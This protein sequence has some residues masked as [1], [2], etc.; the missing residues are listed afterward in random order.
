MNDHE[1][2]QSV[3]RESRGALLGLAAILAWATSAAGV[4]WIGRRLGTWQYL[5]IGCLIGC[6]GQV[7]CYRLLGRSPQD[8]FRLPWRQW[9]LAVLGF[10]LYLTCYAAGLVAAVTD[11]Q[12]VGVSL[13]NYLWPVLT[14]VLAVVLVPGTRLTPRV[15][16]ALAVALGGL[17]V[18]NWREIGRVTGP[19]AVLPYVLGGLAGI[20]WALYSAL[21]ARWRDRGQRYATAPAG[22]LMISLIGAIVCVFQG[23]WRPVTTPTWLALLYVGLVPN[24]AGYL[25]WEWALHRASPVTLGLLG[26]GTPML[27]TLCLLGLFTLT[28]QSRITPHHWGP[29]LL[30]AGL[31]AAAVLLVSVKPGAERTQNLC[32]EKEVTT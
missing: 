15:G 14:V 27:S 31:V 8:L 30:G 9:L 32:A 22:F 2:S 12:A 6:L 24:A 18:A 28:G 10:V 4:Y 3:G 7:A 19:G 21:V 26:A 25:C 5:A 29:W 17:V 20:F 23:D 11:A 13:L 16:A 1:L